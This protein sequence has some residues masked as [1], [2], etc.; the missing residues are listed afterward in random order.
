MKTPSATSRTRTKAHT[1]ENSNLT[2]SDAL[3]SI[4]DPNSSVADRPEMQPTKDY[5]DY[6]KFIN[7]NNQE[8]K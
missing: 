8:R 5:D 2:T 4:I 3:V 1:S 7:D 6:T